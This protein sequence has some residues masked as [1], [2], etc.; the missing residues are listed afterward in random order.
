M[1][2]TC[3]ALFSAGTHIVA[4]CALLLACAGAKAQEDPLAA[5]NGF[6]V[7]FVEA[8]TDVFRNARAAPHNRSAAAVDREGAS[9]VEHPRACKWPPASAGGDWISLPGGSPTYGLGFSETGLA[10]WYGPQFQH[11]RTANGDVFEMSELSAAHRTFPLNS[12]VRVTNLR[13]DRSVVVRV[14]DRGPYV[15]GRV[16]DLSAE[17]ARQLG[18]KDEGV[19]RVR[20]Q[21]VQVSVGR[22]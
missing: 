6:A 18:F 4:S 7:S 16:I 19:V 13:N 20:I 21:L 15:A 3:V 9:R 14:N 11:G 5:T 8:F 2:R 17:A 12:F 10:S 22:I 1:T